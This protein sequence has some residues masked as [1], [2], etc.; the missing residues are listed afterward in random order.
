M[1]DCDAPLNGT[2]CPSRQCSSATKL[3]TVLADRSLADENFP[4]LKFWRRVNAVLRGVG[5]L[6][7]TVKSVMSS[8]LS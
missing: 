3:E 5:T 4:V 8:E 7:S 2:F 6:Q 1:L